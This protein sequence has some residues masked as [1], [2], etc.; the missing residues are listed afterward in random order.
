MATGTHRPGGEPGRPPTR[1]P[2]SLQRWRWCGLAA[3][4]WAVSGCVSTLEVQ[5][6][7]TGRP[8][9]VA[10]SLQGGD[11]AMLR[12]EAERLC[13]LGGD[14]V[15]QYGQQQRPE[16]ADGG[17]WRRALQATAMWIDPPRQAAQLVVA[18]RESGDRMRIQA[19][20][21]APQR[22]AEAPSAP[23]DPADVT[24]ALPVGPV[25]PEW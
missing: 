1:R 6:L 2:V 25:N 8:D 7:A 17:R 9:V 14:V 4:A 24:A 12:R 18:C 23:T 21:P 22:A 11:L 3:L 10:Y 5:T 16:Q 13:P 15:R 19:A 20:T